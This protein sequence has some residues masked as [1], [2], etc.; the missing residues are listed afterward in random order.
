MNC[1]TENLQKEGVDI[2]GQ[3]KNSQR[4]PVPRWGSR[5][6]HQLPHPEPFVNLPYP[7]HPVPGQGDTTDPVN[8]S[9]PVRSSWMAK[10]NGLSTTMVT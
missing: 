2:S 3:V 5:T 7:C 8:R 1:L 9:A 10:K 6:F 4:C